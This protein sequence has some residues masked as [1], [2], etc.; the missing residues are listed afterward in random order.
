MQRHI[1]IRVVA[2]T[3][4]L[5]IGLGLFARGGNVGEMPD[6]MPDKTTAAASIDISP[7]LSGRICRDQT[8]TCFDACYALSVCDLAIIPADLAFFALGGARFDALPRDARTDRTSAPEPH[9]PKYLP[10]T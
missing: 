8:E 7:S 4:A 3:L 9:P 6:Q 1:S 2:F 5:A 10:L